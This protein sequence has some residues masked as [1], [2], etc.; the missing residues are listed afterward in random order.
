MIISSAKTILLLPFWFECHFFFLAWLLWLECPVLCWLGVGSGDSYLIPDLRGKPFNLSPMSMLLA[1]DL[2]YMAFIVL[3]Y[4]AYTTNLLK[5][6][7]MKGCCNFVKFFFASTE[8]IS[9]L[10][11]ILFNKNNLLINYWFAYLEPPLHPRDKAP[12]IML[13]DPSNVQ[14]NSVC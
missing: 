3:R 11:F 14:L 10:F 5:V 2:Q 13:Y 1:V 6:F 12:L 7:I 9:F 4:I 8:M